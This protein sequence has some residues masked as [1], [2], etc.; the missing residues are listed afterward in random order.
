[1]VT[2]QKSLNDDEIGKTIDFALKQ[3]CVRGVTFQ[4]TQIAGRLDHFDSQCDRITLTEVRRKILEQTD[5]F[6]AD[7]IIPV[8]CNP[9]AL[10]MG[11]ALKLGGEVFPLTRYI[12]PKDLLDNSKNTIIYE[13][14]AQL[15]GRM[16]ELFSTG[17]SVEGARDKLHSV[18]CCLP[19]IDAPLLSYNNLFRV[20]IMQFIDA[21]N[22]DVRSIKKSCV[23]I[24]NK[25][26]KIIPFETM[27]L[28]YRDDKKE[29]LEKLRNTVEV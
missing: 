4:P 26:N 13:Q 24:V 8:P 3:K 27:N 14:D 1:V 19:Q 5:V 16:L 23:H 18:L 12:N 7:D 25:D 2:L 29:Y 11:Y 21:Y 9:D 10:A 15:H 28:F 17:N 6:N 20:I 22:F